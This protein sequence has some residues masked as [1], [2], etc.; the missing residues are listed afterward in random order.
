MSAVLPLERICEGDRA[1]I[2]GKAYQLARLVSAGIPVP[3]GFAITPAALEQLHNPTVRDEIGSEFRR[4]GGP[5]A[6]RSS[7]NVEDGAAGSFA[8]QFD[9]VLNLTGVGELFSAIDRCL[10]SRDSE[11]VAAYQRSMGQNV[12]PALAVIVQRFVKGALT[13]VMF[14]RDPNDNTAVLIEITCETDPERIQFDRQS[15]GI[16]SSN[17]TMNLD[18][19]QLGQLA[20]LGQRIELLFG[21]PCDIEWIWDGDQFWMV[22]VRPI[23]TGGHLERDRILHQEIERLRG[24]A[25]AGGTVWVRESLAEAL[26]H[27]TPMTWALVQRMMSGDGGLGR[28]HRDLGCA[29]DPTLGALGIH[30]LIAGSPYLNLSRKPRMEYGDLPLGYSFEQL[31]ARPELAHN[32][33]IRWQTERASWTTWLRLP[34]SLIQIR[35]KT[36]RIAEQSRTFADRF[37]KEIV[38]A[39]AREC[40]AVAKLDLAGLATPNLLDRFNSWSE[41]VLD[42]FARHSLKPAALADREIDD[43]RRAA[44]GTWASQFAGRFLSDLQID[45]RV[46][47]AAG[48]RGLAE[49]KVELNAFLKQFGHRGRL[50]MELSQPRYCESPPVSSSKRAQIRRRNDENEAVRVVAKTE[51]VDRLRQYT[52]LRETAKHYLMLGFFQLRRMLLE[53]DRR[54]ELHGGVFFL[55]PGELPRAAA[56]E[57]FGETIAERRRRWAVLKSLPKPAVI[58]SDDLAA[59]GRMAATDL[60]ACEWKGIAVSAGAAEGPALVLDEPAPIDS[61][62]PYVLVCPTLD[63]NWTPLMMG[64]SA[65]VAEIGG[66]LSHGAIVAREMGVPTVTG[67]GGIMSRVQTGQ[68]LR[69]DGTAGIVVTAP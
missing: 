23:T 61:S 15:A 28:M 3:P 14:T 56:G 53:F 21:H 44:G 5:V 22:Q 38:P 47:V 60:S 1:S 62:E 36:R 11:R 48:L 45:S 25:E 52:R 29:P 2:G 51:Q 43:W 33:A 16:R 35:R 7:A 67:I 46:D 58:F 68:R 19:Q 6:V 65:L 49:G 39:F 55:E 63:P 66:V 8:G 69:V 41:R 30:D 18:A 34:L 54:F 4:L 26:P 59:I 13:G 40:E 27:P 17:T 31:K 37:E 24:L 57:A 42:E 64:A 12:K 50:E 32:A 20:D 9:S 10:K